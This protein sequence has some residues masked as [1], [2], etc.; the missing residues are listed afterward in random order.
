MNVQNLHSFSRWQQTTHTVAIQF[1]HKHYTGTHKNEKQRDRRRKKLNCCRIKY[2]K[3]LIPKKYRMT[4]EHGKSPKK[5]NDSILTF[6]HIFACL[7][8]SLTAICWEWERKIVMYKNMSVE[9]PTYTV[10][11]FST[12]SNGTV[13][14]V[15]SFYFFSPLCCYHFC[16]TVIAGKFYIF[17]LHLLPI[18]ILHAPW[19][20]YHGPLWLFVSKER[21]K[22]ERKW[23]KW[24]HK[25]H[26][27]NRPTDRPT[28][29]QGK[30]NTQNGVEEQREASK[31]RWYSRS[32]D[33]RTSSSLYVNGSNETV[34][35]IAARLISKPS[36]YILRPFY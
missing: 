24:A 23:N 14:F 36:K 4:A 12:K 33:I 32:F 6:I 35:A 28:D 16:T 26:R 1:W 29:Q 22:T 11:S 17:F 20:D 18:T 30:K 15:I 5:E 3:H 27:H 2:D 13:Q 9:R 21:E 25:I 34:C 31:V 10:H 7:L 8:H 19:A